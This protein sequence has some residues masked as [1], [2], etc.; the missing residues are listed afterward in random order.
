[1]ISEAVLRQSLALLCDERQMVLL[2]AGVLA[3]PQNAQTSTIVTGTSTALV[4]TGTAVGQLVGVG[5]ALE[6]A[7]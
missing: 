7:S 1:M 6:Y 5:P 3:Y 2:H 4:P